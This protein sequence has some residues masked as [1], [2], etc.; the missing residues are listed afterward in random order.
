ML[1]FH[2]LDNEKPRSACPKN[3]VIKSDVDV[4]VTWSKGLF[5][6]NVGIQNV[7]FNP[8]NGSIF[9]S[10][11]YHKVVATVTDQQ[12]NVETCVMEVYVKGKNYFLFRINLLS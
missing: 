2:F 10:N 6:D 7:L 9:Q 3:I 5:E 11:K 1:A 4:A 12:N 8:S